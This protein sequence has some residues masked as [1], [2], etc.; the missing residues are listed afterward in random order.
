M[1]WIPESGRCLLTPVSR[2][3]LLEKEKEMSTHSSVPAW[4]ITWTEES[5]SLQSTVSQKS[6]TQFSD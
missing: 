1:G 4:E 6:Q 2:K 5:G 3:C